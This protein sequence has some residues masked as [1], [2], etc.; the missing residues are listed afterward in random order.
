MTYTRTFGLQNVKIRESF[1][2]IVVGGSMLMISILEEYYKN[3][4]LPVVL[5]G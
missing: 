2:D 5:H 4:T 3:L 1:A